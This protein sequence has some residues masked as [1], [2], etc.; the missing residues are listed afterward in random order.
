MGLVIG[1]VIAYSFVV[2]RV[3]F[4]QLPIPFT[5]PWEVVLTVVV[6]A[7]AFSL[8]SSIIPIYTLMSDSIVGAMRRLT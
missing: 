7:M 1:T 2:Q 8:F 3:L 5:F 4:T 6:S